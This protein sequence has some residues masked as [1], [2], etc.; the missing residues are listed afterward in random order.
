MRN[1]AQRRPV[2]PQL[3]TRW[4]DGLDRFFLGAPPDTPQPWHAWHN[5][6][7]RASERRGGSRSLFPVPGKNGHANAARMAAMGHLLA[8]N[9]RLTFWRD[10]ASDSY[11]LPTDAEFQ[12]TT[13]VESGQYAGQPTFICAEHG[14]YESWFA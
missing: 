9:E 14:P 11:V 13:L 1:W 5:R 7:L 12:L 3:A 10:G 2:P 6:G 4:L 8:L